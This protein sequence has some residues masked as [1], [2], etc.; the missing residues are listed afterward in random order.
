VPIG[1]GVSQNS[2]AGPR[3][4]FFQK[5]D[6]FSPAV[7]RPLR[8]GTIHWGTPTPLSLDLLKITCRPY[9]YNQFTAE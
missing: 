4:E 7:P 3:P 1:A 9:K 5:T 6:F 8:D 2:S